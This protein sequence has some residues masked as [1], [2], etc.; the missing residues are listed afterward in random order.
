MPYQRRE[1]AQKIHGLIMECC[2]SRSEYRFDATK[3]ELKKV[4]SRA[5]ASSFKEVSANNFSHLHDILHLV[6]ENCKDESLRKYIGTSLLHL[7]IKEADKI[8]KAQDWTELLSIKT[9]DDFSILQ[10]AV[11]TGN[12]EIMNAIIKLLTTPGQEKALRRN[13]ESVNKEQFTLLQQTA[14]VG[15]LEIVNAIIKLLTAKGQKNA[16]KIN[17]EGITK[18]QFTLLQTAVKTGEPE[19]V[20]AIIELLTAT[21]QKDALKINLEG[22]TNEQFTL[23]QIAVKTGKPEIVNAIIKLLTT[24]GQEEALQTNLKGIN[25]EQFTLL[26]QAAYT[27]K[28]EIVNAIIKLLTVQPAKGQ[29]NVLKIN[30]EGVTKEKFTLLQQAVIAGNLEIVKT[31]IGLQEKHLSLGDLKK[32]LKHS[33]EA[34]YNILHSAALS[35]N[36]EIFF[37]IIEHMLYVFADDEFDA[38]ITDLANQ[39]TNIGR[40]PSSNRNREIEAFLHSYRGRE[41]TNNRTYLPIYG[42]N[43]QQPNTTVQPNHRRETNVPYR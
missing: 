35:N 23:L 11:I 42:R 16:L 15:N 9:R 1:T 26:Q 36:A 18:E 12:L 41:A 4:L 7:F 27:G 22:V 21:D 25:K 30:L 29:E 28:P 31:V 2:H 13:L 19:I 24:P 34:K 33:N 40:I 6:T 17:L 20:N 37:N 10:E 32:Q 38:M 5:S 14:K 43:R 3:G 39:K 8:F